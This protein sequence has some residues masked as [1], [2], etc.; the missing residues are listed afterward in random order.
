MTYDGLSSSTLDRM[1]ERTSRG[2]EVP[3]GMLWPAN[4]HLF[5]HEM[6]VTKI[7]GGKVYLRNP[8]GSDDSGSMGPNRQLLNNSGD[9]VMTLDEFKRYFQRASLS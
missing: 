9:S 2:F 6:L 3:V 8:Y 4:G 1:I 7:E 5:S